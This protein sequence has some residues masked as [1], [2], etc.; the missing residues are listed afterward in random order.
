[1]NMIKITDA[2]R[3]AITSSEVALS[4]FN[5]GYLNLTSYAVS[6]K[7][8]VEEITKKKVR[9]GSIVVALSR[10]KKKLPRQKE[11]SPIVKIDHISVKRGLVEMAF[12]KTKENLT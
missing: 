12:E 10:M 11:L 7:K 2:V 8:E 4:A 6:I 9:I 1:M 5:E 3:D